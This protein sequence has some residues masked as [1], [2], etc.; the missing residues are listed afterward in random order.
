MPADATELTIENSALMLIDHQPWVAFMCEGD[1]TLLLNNVAFLARAAKILGVPT[2]L[3]TVGASGTVPLVDPIFSQIG[4]VFPE[5][6][7]IDRVTT[8]AWSD[9]RVR[10]AVEAT[11]RRKLITAGLST[12]VC[13]AQAVLGALK[14]GYEVYFATDCSAGVTREGH[15]DA[16]LRLVQAGAHPV[17]V[18]VCISEWTPVA[19]SPERAKLVDI[20]LEY[21]GSQSLA[22]QY[23]FAQTAAGTVRTPAP[24][25]AE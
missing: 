10:E 7:P 17:N 21:G 3:T 24:A 8:A 18:P 22:L 23:V 11:G 15:E 20:S 14:D 25:A 4:D 16:K 9:P 19:T 1:Q 6:K 5:I 13:L 12:E 2:V